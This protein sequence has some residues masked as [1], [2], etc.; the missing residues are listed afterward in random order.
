M[1]E[2]NNQEASEKYDGTEMD[3]ITASPY[4][5]IGSFIGFLSLGFIY[6]FI[7]SVLLQP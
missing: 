3:E 5:I 6:I 1:K 7:W 4:I 2:F